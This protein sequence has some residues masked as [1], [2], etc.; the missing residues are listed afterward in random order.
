MVQILLAAEVRPTDVKA[1]ICFLEH[2][3]QRGIPPRAGLVVNYLLRKLS[4]PLEP[5][6][7]LHQHEALPNVTIW[8]VSTSRDHRSG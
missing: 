7:H 6:I 8:G 1:E 5:R 3:I 4:Q 2:L